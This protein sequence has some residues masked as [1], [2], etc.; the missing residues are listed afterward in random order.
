[1]SVG[2]VPQP[3]PETAP[4]WEGTAAGELRI[5]KCLECDEFYFYPRPFCPNCFSEKVEWQ[6]VSGRAKLASYVINYRPLPPFKRDEPQIIA[7]VTLDEGPRLC[8]N[9]ID[10]EPD[11]ANLPLGLE[12]TVRFEERGDQ[13]VPLFAPAKGAN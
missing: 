13:T 9:I 12:L 6:A 2:P 10:V 5:Q 11:P 7:L 1:M 8:T 3:T 4:F